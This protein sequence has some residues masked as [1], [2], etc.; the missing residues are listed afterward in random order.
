MP[1]HPRISV[2]HRSRSSKDR[3]RAGHAQIYARGHCARPRRRAD[4]AA[5]DETNPMP[6][7]MGSV[8]LFSRILADTLFMG[9]ANGK[10]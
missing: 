8:N 9:R 4:G 3:S 7:G 10:E 2:L 6:A 5:V 1:R